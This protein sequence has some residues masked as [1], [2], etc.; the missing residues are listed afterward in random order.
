MNA[1]MM[2]ITLMTMET[3]ANGMLKTLMNVE[4]M[5]LKAVLGPQVLHAAHVEEAAT[6]NNKKNFGLAIL[7]THMMHLTL[8]LTSGLRMRK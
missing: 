7:S 1:T 2:N 3:T 5:T 6:R 4:T 8:M